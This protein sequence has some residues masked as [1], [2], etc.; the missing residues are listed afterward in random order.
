MAKD[1]L[2]FCHNRRHWKKGCLKLQNNDKMNSNAHVI[3]AKDDDLEL[4]LIVL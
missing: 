1:V 3:H 2:L 4:A